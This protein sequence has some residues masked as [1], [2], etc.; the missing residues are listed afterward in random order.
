MA[1]EVYD[2]LSIGLG[3]A[4]LSVSIALLEENSAIQSRRNHGTTD[5]YHRPDQQVFSSLG[6]LQDALRREKNDKESD[7]KTAF[8]RAK[9][10]AP[11]DGAGTKERE[12]SFYSIEAHGTFKWHPGMMLEGSRMQ[13]SYVAP[14]VDSPL[15]P[16][17]QVLL[18]A[19]L[20][21]RLILSLD[22]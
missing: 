11:D 16:P 10:L 2:V 7:S 19:P 14:A 12:L 15:F 6:G 1:V 8:R 5:T 4:A 9:N 20:A 3:P 22:F 18:F 13:I 17:V 21:N